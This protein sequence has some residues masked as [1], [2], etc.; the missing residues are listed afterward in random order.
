M[1]TAM[2]DAVIVSL[3][4]AS[5]AVVVLLGVIALLLNFRLFKSLARR[6][7]RIEQELDLIRNYLVTHDKEIARLE[8]RQ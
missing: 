8:H 7:R 3:V 1:V 4:N 5:G 2:S 6:I